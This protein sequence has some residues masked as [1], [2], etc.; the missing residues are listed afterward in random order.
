MLLDLEIIQSSLVASVIADLTVSR[1]PV[2]C[3]VTTLCCNNSGVNLVWNLGV[4]DPGPKNFDFYREI[5]EKF[6]FFSGN[7]KKNI[8]VYQAK[9]GHLQLPLGK[10]F[11]FSSKVTTFEHTSSTW[12]DIIIFHEPS[13]APTTTPAAPTTTPA[14]PRP[15]AQNLGIG[16][17]RIDAPA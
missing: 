10:L 13:T 15:P 17:P 8:S 14:T 7:L 16:N 11:Y 12:W 2:S 4:V 3:Y 9:I 1:I 6:R 5:S